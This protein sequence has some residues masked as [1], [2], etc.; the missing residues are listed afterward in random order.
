MFVVYSMELEKEERVSEVILRN[1]NH[2]P[3]VFINTKLN[4]FISEVAT[5]LFSVSQHLY[6]MRQDDKD[7]ELL[8]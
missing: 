4:M 7:G 6:T 5:Q 1:Y 2:N 8:A 3:S